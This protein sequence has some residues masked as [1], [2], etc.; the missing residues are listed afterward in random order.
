MSEFELRITEETD[1]ILVS[2]VKWSRIV[3][4]FGFLLAG[5]FVLFGALIL[6]NWDDE[7]NKSSDYELASILF[8]IG[9][10]LFSPSYFALKASINLKL[11]AINTV[12]SNLNDGLSFAAKFFQSIVVST[13]AFIL[14]C[15]MLISYL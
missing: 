8:A 3:A 7:P 5:I 10:F 2:L 4:Y 1:A 14:V 15:Y 13:I 12:Q 9:V 6:V 11:A